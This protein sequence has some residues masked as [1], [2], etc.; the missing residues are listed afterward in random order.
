[1]LNLRPYKKCD[2]KKVLSFIEDEQTFIKWSADR[3][4]KYPIT[5]DEL[6]AHYAQFD[7]VEGYF[8][9]VAYD[10]SGVVGHILMR[11]LDEEKKILRFGFVIV[12]STKRGKGY[13]KKLMEISLKY[14][15]EFLSVD[16]VTIGVF[17]GNEAARNCYLSVGFNLTG[18]IV[19]CSVRD[20][21][22]KI[23][24]LEYVM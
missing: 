2:G 13:G 11:F 22:Y 17:D 1:M 5:A 8:P 7:N 15:R 18:E 6:N 4:D 24:E 21:M 23:I 19:E 16:K 3:F 10:E 9:M 12:D 20:E 14:A